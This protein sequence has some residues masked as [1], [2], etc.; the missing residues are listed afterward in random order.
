[1]ATPRI[2]VTIKAMKNSYRVVKMWRL[3]WYGGQT[4]FRE[5]RRKPPL[6][7][8]PRP[9]ARIS[10]SKTALYPHQPPFSSP[11][12]YPPAHTVLSTSSTSLSLNSNK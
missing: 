2:D 6:H 7:P 9:L 4:P 12:V 10:S 11:A 3:Q 8:P 1:M 5:K